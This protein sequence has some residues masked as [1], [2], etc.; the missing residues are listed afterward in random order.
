MA[1]DIEIT[2]GTGANVATDD[3]T[4]GHVQL[5]KLAYS[6]DGNRTHVS[7]DANGVLVNLGANN[8]VI[9]TNMPGAIAQGSGTP[10]L[11]I[12]P[13]VTDGADCYF[14]KGDNSGLALGAGSQVIG[15]VDLRSGTAGPQKS[16]DSASINADVGIPAMAVRKA[17][18][19]D[20]SSADGDYE[21]LQMSAGRLW[22]SSTIDAALP[23]G[24]NKIGDVVPA[25]SIVTY[26]IEL[27]IDAN[28]YTAN[29][30]L[31]GL[32]ELTNAVR[33]SGGTGTLLKVVLNDRDNERRAIDLVFFDRSVST[34]N[35][36]AFTPSDTDFFFIEGVI[37]IG[38]YNT[39][40]QGALNA[41]STLWNIGFPFKCNGTS[42]YCQ[43]VVRAAPT[44]NGGQGDLKMKFIIQRD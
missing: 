42:L 10:S 3:C 36:S 8:D 20:T 16:E 21:F 19:A 17:A 4:T 6:A 14:L 30:C 13:V 38:P 22:T 31:G 25:P 32:I 35:N 26:E 11:G 15:Y 18:P 44:Y 29:D 34:T 28:A 40:W 33:A 2:P 37:P 12:L 5:V 23:A 27:A 41:T 7:A 1:D 43:P 9:V 24:T 39:A